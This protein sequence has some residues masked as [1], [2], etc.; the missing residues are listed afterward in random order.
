[1]PLTHNPPSDEAS[2]SRSGSSTPGSL[3]P[4]AAHV[5]L[6]SILPALLLEE[7]EGYLERIVC[8][9]ST[10]ALTFH[11]TSALSSAWAEFQQLPELLIITSHLGCNIDGERLPYL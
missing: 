6:K 10:I 8:Y 3:L 9:G 2:A 11:D 5:R 1:M 4:F 7:H